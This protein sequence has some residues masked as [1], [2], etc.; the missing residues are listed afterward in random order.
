ME[1]IKF[2]DLLAYG[3]KS[4]VTISSLNHY[5]ARN[6]RVKCLFYQKGNEIT[7]NIFIFAAR[8][9][10]GFPFTYFPVV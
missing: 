3:N 5:F 7:G 10:T 9:A 1:V 8:K 6:L 2:M 4:M